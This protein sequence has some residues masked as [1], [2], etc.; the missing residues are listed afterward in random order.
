MVETD[1]PHADSTW[2]N[3]QEL[4]RQQ[5]SGIPA[6]EVARICWANASDLFRH[7]VPDSVVND[8][9]SF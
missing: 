6:D 7:P 2:P 4:L 5:L 1:Y 8:P 9:E 3:T